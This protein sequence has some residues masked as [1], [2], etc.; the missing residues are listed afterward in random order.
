METKFKVD[1]HKIGTCM[2]DLVIMTNNHNDRKVRI[3]I[4]VICGYL[5]AMKGMHPSFNLHIKAEGEN[6]QT[7]HISDDGGKTFYITITEQE[8][9]EFISEDGRWYSKEMAKMYED[10]DKKMLA[11]F[12][13]FATKEREEETIRISKTQNK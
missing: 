10:F 12:K 4:D 13:P 3:D 8:N 6:S 9:A 7:L 1:I 2:N 5:M 11:G